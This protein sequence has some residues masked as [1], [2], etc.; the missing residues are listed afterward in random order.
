MSRL[1]Y[2]VSPLPQSRLR[3]NVRR[4]LLSLATALVLSVFIAGSLSLRSSAQGNAREK[5]FNN[6]ADKVLQIVR[7]A[8]EEDRRAAQKGQLRSETSAVKRLSRIAKVKRHSDENVRINVAVTLRDNSESE[9]KAAGFQVQS[10]VGDVATLDLD[11]DQLDALAALESVRKIFASVVR[12]PLNDRAR[13]SAGIDNSSGQRLVT[14]TGRGVVVG[15]IDTGIDFRHLDFTVPGSGGHQTRIKAMLDMT[16]Y[17]AQSPDPG[18][19]YSLPGQSAVIGHL[20]TEADINSALQIPKP[21]DQNADLVRQRDKNGHGTH[22]AGTAAGNGLSSPTPGTYAGMAPEADLII[23]KASRQNDGDADFDTTDVINALEFIKQK[24]AELGEPFVINLSIGGQL[25]AHDG[26]TPDERAIDNLVNGGA[27]RAVCVAAGNEGGASIHA[28]STVPAGGSQTLDFNVNG[29]AYV[30][31]LYQNKSD[32]FS[33]TVTSPDGVTLGPVAYDANGFTDPAGQGSNQYVQIFNANDDK[34]DADS[35]NDQPD[36]VVLFKPAAPDGM[37]KVTLTDADGN[38]NQSYDAWTEGEGVYFSTF[39]DN[40]SHLVASPGTARGAITVGAFVTRAT[41]QT[42][43]G[44]ASFTSPGPTADGRQKPDIGAPGYYLYSSRSTDITDPNFGIFGTGENASTDSTHYAG[45]A[46]TSMATPVTTGSVALLIQS[47]PALFANEIK[48]L[49]T[50]YA[51]LD[52]F[53]GQGPW[54]PRLGFGKL[55]IANSINRTGGGF[56]KFSISGRLADPDGSPVVDLQVFLSGTSSEMARTD[57]NGNFSFNNLPAGGNYTVSPSFQPSMVFSPT[58]YNFNSLSADQTANFTRTVTQTYRVGG[59]ITDTSGNGVSGVRVEVPGAVTP[60]GNLPILPATTDINGYYSWD[61]PKGQ[62]YHVT[63]TSGLHTFT[64]ASITFL[65]LSAGQTANFTATAVKL[66]ITGRVTNG[67]NG[68]P[69]VSMSMTAYASAAPPV[70]VLTDAN[71]FYTFGDVT[72]GQYYT[73]TPSK[74]NYLF[75]PA[76]Q[77][78]FLSPYVQPTPMFIGSDN[79][80]DN[81]RFFVAQHYRD[82]LSREP[83]DSGLNFWTNDIMQCGTNLVCLE[84]RRINTSGAFFLSIEFQETGYL[85]ERIYKSAYGDADGT[86]VLGGTAHQ[87]K[88]PIIR[89]NEFLPDTQQIGKN[90]I[91]QVGDWQTQLENNKV[92]FTQEFVTRTRFTTAYP[93]TMTPA[94]FV[95]ALFLKAGVTPTADERSSIINEFGGAGT[96]AD[97]AARARALRRVAENTVLKQQEKNKAFVLMQY[98]GYLRRDPN[99]GQDSD[100]TG[101]DY[102]LKKLNDFDGNFINAEMVKAFLV[103]IEYRQRFGP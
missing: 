101:Y 79:A 66:S 88:V 96:S 75:E 91:V 37:W 1:I 5:S 92:A 102:W 73:I 53:T 72:S 99:A 31:D 12:H 2:R 84:A 20:Y 50:T 19:N 65:N 23:V 8:V 27:G 85:V 103:S 71:G 87:I 100:H 62:D 28:R 74:T 51:V 9:L 32:R 24:A 40:D 54:S 44:P 59:R 10:R 43:G 30:I 16:E 89:L 77:T 81:S 25:G 57:A 21:S 33:V 78:V 67:N 49:L 94:E 95:D 3:K 56:K 52:I 13:Q 42:I 86:S 90:V 38:A 15:I 35:A 69:G 14:Q 18:W 17:G 48:N 76:S 80:I 45:L 6:K 83:D 34:G 97:T 11:V 98:F 36:I 55:N 41:T 46:G 64:P 58:L 82:F 60:S 63:P 22:V 29:E 68:V 61:L 7:Q 93:T 4:A 39:V 70:V 26:T 47:S